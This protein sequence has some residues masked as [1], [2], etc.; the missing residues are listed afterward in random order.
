MIFPKELVKIANYQQTRRST[1]SW[2]QCQHFILIDSPSCRWKIYSRI[3]RSLIEHNYR[4]IRNIMCTFPPS[5]DLAFVP[6][7]GR[8]IFGRCELIEF[9]R[10][11]DLHFLIRVPARMLRVCLLNY[12]PSFP[13]KLPLSF[14]FLS[15]ARVAP[16]SFPSPH[17]HIRGGNGPRPPSRDWRSAWPGYWTKAT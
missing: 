15:V 1:L 10:A 2:K 11:R 9:L 5:H 3:F 13:T 7:Q 4:E 6:M 8:K 16:F 14:L 17:A 12:R